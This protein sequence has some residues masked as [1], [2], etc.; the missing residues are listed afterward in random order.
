MNAEIKVGI[1]KGVGYGTDNSA[2]SGYNK[3]WDINEYIEAKK[4]KQEKIK[5]LL[6]ILN[7]FFNGKKFN[8]N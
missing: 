3:Q 1:I 6:L 4:V 2:F 8:P 7:A 5:K